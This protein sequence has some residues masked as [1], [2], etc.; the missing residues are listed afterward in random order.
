MFSSF[1]SRSVAALLLVLIAAPLLL[2]HSDR[3]FSNLTP[4]AGRAFSVPLLTKNSYTQTVFAQHASLTRVGVFLQAGTKNI[5][6][7]TVSITVASAHGDTRTAVFPSRSIDSEGST[8]AHFDNPLATTPGEKLTITL[9]VSP[10]LNNLVS[11]QTRENDGSFDPATLQFYINGQPQAQPFAYQMYYDYRPPL[12]LQLAGILVFVAIA[13]LAWPRL[14]RRPLLA[15]ALAYGAYASL[16]ACIPALTAGHLPLALFA[17][18]ALIA[19]IFMYF[20]QPKVGWLPALAGA[21]VAAFTSWFALH[22]LFPANLAW[23]AA[24]A[25]W[26]DILFDPNQVPSAM[27]VAG[28]NWANFGSYLGFINALLAIIGLA[29]FGKKKVILLVGTIA[30]FLLLPF[31]H[32]AIV[33]TI[34][35]AVWTSFGLYSLQTFLGR[36]SPWIAILLAVLLIISLLDLW[37]VLAGPLEFAYLL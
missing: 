14:Q 26:R 22:E 5:P 24:T 27:K 4:T 8:Q 35:A 31:A 25:A 34:C 23:T 6:D 30:A 33:F 21:H 15:Q 19:A 9:S 7:G 20:L 37:H 11:L 29:S 2:V 28:S 18:K 16:L 3:E 32:L 12:A 1:R 17:T 13:L 36:H 10:S